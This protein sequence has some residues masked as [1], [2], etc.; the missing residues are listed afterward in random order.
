MSATDRARP[1]IPAKGDTFA[2]RPAAPSAPARCLHG[3]GALHRIGRFEIVRELG[4]GS[5]GIVFLARDPGLNREIALKVPRPEAILTPQLRSRFLREGKA[6]ARLNHPNIVPVHEAGEAGPIC[7]LVQSY[8]SGP[9]LA[10]WLAN[11]KDPIECKLAAQIVAELADGVDHAHQQG[12]LH[13]DIKPANVML[14]IGAVRAEGGGRR[15]KTDGPSANFTPRLTD[16]GLAKALDDDPNATATLGAVGTATYMPPEQAEGKLSLVGPR[17]DVY[18]LGALLY[19]LL[20]RRPPIAGVNQ[21]ETLRLIACEEPLP[22]RELRTDVPRELEAVCLKCLE[23]S[24]ERRY[25]S[26]AALAADLR[27]YLNGERVHASPQGRVRRV[28]RRLR[29]QSAAKLAGGI[30]MMLLAAGLGLCLTMMI[31]SRRHGS[32]GPGPQPVDPQAEYIAGL[33][34]VAQGY[35]DAVANRG[36]TQTAVRGLD[37][38]LERHRPQPGQAD[39]RGF[40]WH[41]LWRLCH[42][43]QV[44]KPFPKLFD[45]KGHK[46]EVYFV[47]FS[48]DGTLLATAGQDRIGRIWET[49]TGKLHATLVGHTADVNW[50]SFHPQAWWERRV[51]TAGDDKTVRIWNCDTGKPEGVL[52]TGDAPAVAV[53]VVLVNQFDHRN[54][55][56]Q[57]SQCEIVCGDHVGRLW[58]WDWGTRRLLHSVQEHGGRIQAISSYRQGGWWITASNDGSGASGM[59]GPAPQSALTSQTRGFIRF[60]ATR[61]R[62]WPLS[63]PAVR[64]EKQEPFTKE[65]PPAGSSAPKS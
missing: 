50:I 57:E 10:A 18:S 17:S 41:Y 11:E 65:T 20:T 53:E 47:T 21:L 42:P 37:D 28:L 15:E 58:V 36:D 44:A 27:R 55:E 25:V 3:C 35:L 1:R 5:H 4:R 40:E 34:G 6:A 16:F 8:C 14:E 30:A 26:A 33:D 61:N 48:P 64:D 56:Q 9:S 13:R 2:A 60:P 12:V 52:S 32:T 45:L 22:I 59:A 46:G 49:A 23:K 29:R 43:E 51:L 31:S 63:A 24:P 62:P 54:G 38:F 19:E 39:Y 7:Y